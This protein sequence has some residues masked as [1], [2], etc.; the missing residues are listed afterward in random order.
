LIRE[1]LKRIHLALGIALALPFALLGITGSILALGDATPAAPAAHARHAER[2]AA[3][4]VDAIVHAAEAA[5]A[6]GH[7]VTLYAAGTRGAPARVAFSPQLQLLVDPGTL[8]VT[9]PAA[10]GGSLYAF[11]HDLHANVLA[12]AAGRQIVGW[13]GLGTLVLGLTAPFAWWPGRRQVREA[14]AVRGN[15]GGFRVY[16]DLHRAAGIWALAFL[17]ALSLT[18]TFIVFPDPI[19]RTIAAIFPAR[20]VWR[21]DA[22]TVRERGAAPMAAS[23]AI[24]LAHSAAG[25]GAVRTVGFA[26]TDRPLRVEL[27]PQGRAPSEGTITV[28]I[29]P[30]AHRVADVRDPR[31]Y[32]LGERIITTLRPLHEG[33]IL[34]EPWRAALFV[35]GLCPI[36]FAVTGIAMWFVKRRPA[37]SR[38]FTR[39]LDPDRV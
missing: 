5:A 13:L 14:F 9:R 18:G 28:L 15:A 30:W 12:G 21:N 19:G 20:A 29:D 4:N 36:F 1:T 2:S 16:R 33:H 34:G 26:G 37:R 27:L 35:I 6:P 10:R 22:G 3:P 17:V 38:A 39:A 11:A 32:S 23:E 25:P 7:R 24:A 31:T 8:A